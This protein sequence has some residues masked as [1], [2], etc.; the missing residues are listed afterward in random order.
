MPY[1]LTDFKVLRNGP[2]GVTMSK[3][4]ASRTN[5][6]PEPISD[7]HQFQRQVAICVNHPPQEGAIALA[8]IHALSVHLWWNSILL[9]KLV[10]HQFKA[11]Q[12]VP[13]R[14]YD[15]VDLTNLVL[16]KSLMQR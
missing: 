5:A 8:E 16:I 2:R 9:F 12:T 11:F 15:A 4:K 1:Q 14:K 3:Q 10:S 6:T 13:R 7:S